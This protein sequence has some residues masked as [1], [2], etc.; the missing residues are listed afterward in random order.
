MT[1]N[2]KDYTGGRIGIWMHAHQ[3]VVSNFKVTDISDPA[4]MPTSYCGGDER[5][6]C[7]AGAT[8]LCFAVS[9]SGVCEG[10]VGGD[11]YDTTNLDTFEYIDDLYIDGGS[12]GGACIWNYGPNNYVRQAQN[13]WGNLGAMLGCNAIAGDKEYTDFIAEMWIYN[14]DDDGVGFN[15]GWKSLDDHFRVHKMTDPFWNDQADFVNMPHFKMQRRVLGT[16]CE[17]IQTYNASCEFCFP[18][19]KSSK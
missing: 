3:M 6:F 4:N 5:A 1:Y 14:L 15:F 12:G 19:I 13:S 17:G 8:G 2:L 10:A 11:V 16:S 18:K 7:D 9:A